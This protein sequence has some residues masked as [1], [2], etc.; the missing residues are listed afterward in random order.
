MRSLCLCI[1]LAAPAL[2]QQF[3]V[4]SIKPNNSMSGDSHSRTD[5]GI[6]TGTNISLRSLILRAYDIKPYQLEGPDWLGSEHFD[7]SAKIPETV[8]AQRAGREQYKAAF[9][10]MMQSMLA[11]RFKLAVHRD[12]KTMGVYALV[13]AKNGIKFK[14][15]PDGGHSSANTHNTHFTGTGISMDALAAVL[16][17]QTDIPV[18]NFTGLKGVYDMKLDWQDE[19]QAHDNADA[20]PGPGLTEAVEDQ[21]GLRLERRKAPVE[22]VVV[23]HIEKTPTE[24]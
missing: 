24:N 13:V 15:V 3:E 12:R 16:S 7:I 2:A 14:Q 6:M 8:A 9:E 1:L 20:P 18:I 4:V 23:D 11:E 19:R 21:L 5:Q 17:Q 10:S 22:I